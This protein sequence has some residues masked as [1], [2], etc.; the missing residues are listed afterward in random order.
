M[1]ISRTFMVNG[2]AIKITSNEPET[3]ATVS[4]LDTGVIAPGTGEFKIGPL[5]LSTDM[6]APGGSLSLSAQISG[7]NIAYIYTE[8]LFQDKDL[9]YFYGPL[10][11]EYVLSGKNEEVQSVRYPVWDTD[12]K[13]SINITPTLR[14]LT[15]GVDSAFA[16]MRPVN[17]GQEGYHLDG[18]YAS[19]GTHDLQRTRLKFD[20][21][22]ELTSALVFKEKGGRFIPHALT[23]KSGDQFSPIVQV[24]TGSN[25]VCPVACGVST[26]LTWQE[27]AFRWVNETPTNGDYLLGLV[28]QDMDGER[29][30]QYVPFTLSG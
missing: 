2:R 29:T 21:T 13:L 5:N 3:A 7:E 30:R 6:I 12:I 8:I 28:V 16:F 24:L 11:Q 22:G 25:T 19:E 4:A 15:D 20:G 18:L 26:K 9:G 10:S 17:Y 27:T 1:D 23:I 14:I